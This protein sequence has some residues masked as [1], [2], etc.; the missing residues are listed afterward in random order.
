MA[1][2]Y[3]ELDANVIRAREGD[4]F[5]VCAGNRLLRFPRGPIQTSEL[6]FGVLTAAA[7]GE[8]VPYSPVFPVRRKENSPYSFI[9]LGRTSNCDLP[10]PDESVSKLHAILRVD[11]G[12]V[13]VQDAGSRNGTEVNGEAVLARSSDSVPIEP[14]SRLRFGS[15]AMIYVDAEGLLA[16]LASK[17][18]GST[19][20]WNI[21]PTTGGA[22]QPGDPKRLVI[23][24]D[25]RTQRALLGDALRD[26]GFEVFDVE[27]PFD[28]V[29]AV[30][31]CDPDLVL[32]DFLMP[33][34]NGGALCQD[35]KE[36]NPNR[37]VWLISALDASDLAALKEAYG[38]DDCADKAAGTEHL[39][40]KVKEALGS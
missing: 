3:P 2:E 28:A 24:D 17:R 25:S 11:E 4:A 13:R 34:Q 32:V 23:V 38:A 5:F 27:H 21:T 1:D 22:R 30:E 18:R 10:V 36:A 37:N 39:V 19:N 12:G 6:H 33:T 7:R 8:P 29:A 31:E 35:L 40:E 20:E 15:V 26:E 16:L 14:G 9:T